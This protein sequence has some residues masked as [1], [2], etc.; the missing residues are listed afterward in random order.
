[1]EQLDIKRHVSDTSLSE[2]STR[3]ISKKHAGAAQDAQPPA[4][5]LRHICSSSSSS[6]SLN[7]CS[8]SCSSS[9]TT[10]T[11]HATVRLK[12]GDA[13]QSNASS[14]K[15]HDHTRLRTIGRCSA[16][17]KESKTAKSVLHMHA[18][19]LAHGP[20]VQLQHQRPGRNQSAPSSRGPEREDGSDSDESTGGADRVVE[21]TATA[22]LHGT[23]RVLA[24]PT[25]G[26]AGPEPAHGTCDPGSNEEEDEDSEWILFR[27]QL[28]RRK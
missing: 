22:C 2:G 10:G 23:A 13:L 25:R 19:K 27:A 11:S 1:M 21:E 9:I 7:R 5:L 15:S 6:E 8:S 12:D 20:S 28:Q 3:G 18:D 17:S 26:T 4:S 14:D 24:L 16:Q